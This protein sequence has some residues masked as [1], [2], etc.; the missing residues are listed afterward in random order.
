MI[1]NTIPAD[2]NALIKQAIQ[3][4]HDKTPVKW[5]LF[6]KKKN[7]DPKKPYVAFERAID[8]DA[9]SQLGCCNDGRQ[10]IVLTYPYVP[11]TRNK[12]TKVGIMHEVIS[13]H[14]MILC[15]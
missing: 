2:L 4:F 8:V 5:I 6:D 10:L 3:E 11:R 14:M 7:K 1:E 15:T 13:V 9:Y 12:W